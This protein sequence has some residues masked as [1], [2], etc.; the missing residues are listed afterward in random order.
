MVKNIERKK[1]GEG[2]KGR[3]GG[4]REWGRETFAIPGQ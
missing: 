4:E 1:R 3:K 2:R